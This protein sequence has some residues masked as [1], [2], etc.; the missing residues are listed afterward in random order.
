MAVILG[1]KVYNEDGSVTVTWTSVTTSDTGSSVFTGDM[2]DRTIHNIGTGTP[3]IGSSNDGAAFVGLTAAGGPGTPAVMVANTLVVHS[4]NSRFT[5]IVSNAAAT[6]TV[7]MHG[8]QR[9]T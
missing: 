6:T 1:K 2:E 3:Q 8:R 5:N 9:G 4:V 7:I